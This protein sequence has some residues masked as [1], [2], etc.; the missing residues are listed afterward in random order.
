M[1]KISYVHVLS[2]EVTCTGFIFYSCEVF[3]FMFCNYLV[4]VV[5]YK[6]ELCE[7]LY[8]KVGVSVLL[9]GVFFMS[10]NQMSK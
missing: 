2:S 10:L 7:W 9:N 8:D 3:S 5:D 6:S 1:R 4:F